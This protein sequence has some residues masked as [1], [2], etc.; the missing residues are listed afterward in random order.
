M[1]KK[2]DKEIWTREIHPEWYYAIK[3]RKVLSIEAFHRL[4]INM[5]MNF[6]IPINK[7]ISGKYFQEYYNTDPVF[8]SGTQEVEENRKYL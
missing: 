3:E 7:I 4:R 8:Y 5:I 2:K 6:I 1:P